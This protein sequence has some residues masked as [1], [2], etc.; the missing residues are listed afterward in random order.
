MLKQRNRRLSKCERNDQ[1]I[2][3]SVLY[4]LHYCREWS[5]RPKSL[6]S[7]VLPNN[8]FLF[9]TQGYHTN[10]WWIETY[11]YFY[12]YFLQTL[13]LFSR[14][15]QGL[16]NCW[17]NLKLFQ[18]FNTLYEPCLSPNNPRSFGTKQQTQNIKFFYE[19]AVWIIWG[20]NLS[21]KYYYTTVS[22]SI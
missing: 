7:D 11:F 3:C 20:T 21:P 2:D 1:R 4:V 6:H 16:E 15:F 8:N 17:T 19:L 13:S 5:L 22:L 10:R 14:L 9:Q 18:E 12:F